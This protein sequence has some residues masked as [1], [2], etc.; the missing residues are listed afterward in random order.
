M[1]GKVVKGTFEIFKGESDGLF[2]FRLRS[3]YGTAVME[4]AEC[5][6]SK[7]ACLRAIQLVQGLARG[8]VVVDLTEDTGG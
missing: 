4:S 3:S 5:Y 6:S 8:A 2:C 1:P 7:D